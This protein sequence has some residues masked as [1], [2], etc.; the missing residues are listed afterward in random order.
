M[1]SD[2]AKLISFKD[3]LRGEDLDWTLRLSRAGFLTREYA[4]EDS[5]IHYI[6]NMGDRK[7]DRGSL[8]IQSKTS[9]ETM[10][11][12]VWTPNGAEMPSVSQPSAIPILRLGPRG[13]VSK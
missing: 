7:V 10:L 8:E 1:M 12:A 9:Y 3:S 13:F 11:R 4:S 2:I 5:R 6:Y